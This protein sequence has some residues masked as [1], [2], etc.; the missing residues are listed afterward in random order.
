MSPFLAPDITYYMYVFRFF[1]VLKIC[2]QN[3]WTRAEVRGEPGTNLILS[4]KL[5]LSH[6]EKQ[7]VSQMLVED[8]LGPGG[9]QCGLLRPCPRTAVCRQEIPGPEAPSS[10]GTKALWNHCLHILILAQGGSQATSHTQSQLL[11]LPLDALLRPSSS[12]TGFGLF[13]T[14]FLSRNPLQ[15]FHLTWLF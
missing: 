11:P 15:G 1:D 2:S 14:W 12:A 7:A 5:G 6:P 4:L 10:K 9:A 8:R 13:C 3:L